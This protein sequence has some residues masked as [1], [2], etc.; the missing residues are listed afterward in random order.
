MLPLLVW[1]TLKKVPDKI[2]SFV[3]NTRMKLKETDQKFVQREQA[4]FK[5]MLTIYCR[6]KHKTHGQLCS[7]CQA[8]LD[9]ANERV[10][11]CLFLPEK[12]VCA[13]CPVHCYKEPWRGRVREVM[14]FAGPRLIFR[15]PVAVLRHVSLLLRN[16]SER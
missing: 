9:Y 3:Y 14:R 16:D 13:K 12:P 15:D 4:T 1:M 7:D 2:T 8:L 6:A 10:E 11:N 5:S